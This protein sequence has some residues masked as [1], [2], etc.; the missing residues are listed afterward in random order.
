M[1]RSL[2][3]LL[4]L[5]PVTVRSQETDTGFLILSSSKARALALGGA[6]VSIQDDLAAI[7]G[8]PAVFSTISS[9]EGVFAHL[10]LNPLGP[11][12]SMA[13]L[14]KELGW[15]SH[16][17]WTIR[18]VSLSWGRMR[19]GIMLGE[20][21]LTD[22][23]RLKRSKP[24]DA[25]RYQYNRKNSVVFTLLL[26]PRVQIGAGGDLNIRK[27][28]GDTELFWGYRYGILIKPRENINV[29]LCFMN[30][31]DQFH[32][33][34]MPLERFAD[35]TLNIGASY[36][37]WN[38]LTLSMDVRNVSDDVRGAVREIHFGC[39]I[40]PIQHMALRLGYFS[41]K[42]WT[43]HTFSAGIGLLNGN[44]FVP[45]QK[46]FGHRTF[47]VNA[48]FILGKEGKH[49]DKWIVLTCLVRL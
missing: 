6:V 2:I 38:A 17:L 35:E 32:D 23:T 41:Q 27:Q 25:D 34:R 18:G 3:F 36:T 20:E 47:A 10:F 14:N 12:V 5:L 22:T 21:S 9:T 29:G 43:K 16:I 4:I 28:N 8:N 7:D 46:Q 40:Q 15:E 24:L 26:A 13:N 39:E 11:V 33:E 31:P 44:T 45:F 48:A 37:P 49:M 19:F 42:D 1:K 30:L